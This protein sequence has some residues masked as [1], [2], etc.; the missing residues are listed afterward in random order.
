MKVDIFLWSHD[1]YHM[2]QP[3]GSVKEAFNAGDYEVW[4]LR[5]V[6]MEGF[7]RA[8]R[9]TEGCGRSCRRVLG[10]RTAGYCETPGA[11]DSQD[12]PTLDQGRL[13]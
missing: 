7:S 4:R 5:Y 13:E 3:N 10:D 6:D 1:Q 2:A 9:R 11:M 12:P 8:Q